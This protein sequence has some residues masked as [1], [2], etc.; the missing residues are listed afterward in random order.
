MTW[1]LAQNQE[2]IMKKLFVVV[3]VALVVGGCVAYPIGGSDGTL[4]YVPYQ[5]GVFARVVNNCAP[6]LDLETVNGVV[7]Q[8]LPYGNSVTVPLISMPFGGSNRRMSLT[9][10]GYT[11]ERQYLGSLTAQFYVSTYQGSRSEVWEVNRLY[12]PNGRGGCQ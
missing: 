10:K 9:A 3:L 1:N 6:L 2:D 8:G 7:V 11:V 12:L 5:V 4:L